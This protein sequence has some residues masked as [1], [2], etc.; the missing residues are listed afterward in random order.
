VNLINLFTSGQ[1]DTNSTV[2]KNGGKGHNLIEM[3]RS[4]INVPTGLVIPTAICNQYR[5]DT[6]AGKTLL[7]DQVT[8]AVMEALETHIYPETNHKLLSVR[9][10]APV[11][12]AGM[13]DTLL[14]VGAGY[15]DKDLH[16][17]LKADC[18]RRFVE[19]YADVVMEHKGKI[20]DPVKWMKTIKK[21]IPEVKDII[22]NSIQAVWDSFDNERCVHY[23]K[24]NKIPND[25]GTAVVIQSMVFG[26]YN[27]NSGSGVMFTRNPNT[28]AKEIFG[29]FLTNCQGED[30][31][32]GAITAPP[33]SEM[34][35]W[36]SKLYNELV[37]IGEGLEL[38]NKDLQE[39]EF[40]VEDGVLSILQTRNPLR[41]SYAEIKIALDLLEEGVIEELGDRITEGTF[42]KLRVPVLPADFKKKA[43][44]KGIGSGGYFAT[45]KAAFSVKEVMESAEPTI[46]VAEETT[47]DDIKAM[48]KA[49]GIL[50]FKGS[51]TCHAAVVA[52]GMNKPCVVGCP[53]VEDDFAFGTF[54]YVLIDGQTG[55]VYLSEM[56][57]DLEFNTNIPVELLGSLFEV[58][59]T[60]EDWIMVHNYE[61][62]LSLEDYIYKIGV[63]VEGLTSEELIDLAER[64]D[65]VVL[66]NPERRDKVSD[67]LGEP[68]PEGMENARELDSHIG[69]YNLENV[70][71]DSG[72][73]V[74]SN[75]AKA[76][77]TMADVMNPDFIGYIEKDFI[78][79]VMGDAETFEKISEQLG[80]S[81]RV[82]AMES[83]LGL[84]EKRIHIG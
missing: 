70:F 81:S 8:E 56:P 5:A 24:M 37:K 43:N 10:G 33:I 2:N 41:S 22:R 16:K 53:D 79:N 50:T 35:K 71:F 57:F 42:M 67:F 38:K 26:N 11:S 3:K 30:V 76:Y 32:A 19:M 63:P 28:G 49:E 29:D 7:L 40:T 31:V 59:I 46:L 74:T 52:R 20:E 6:D 17:E 54:S 18:R 44:A 36:N 27:D 21:H 60:E 73:W 45:G 68:N 83:A 58:A 78:D 61:E 69:D 48:E 62:A 14:N 23:R 51:A 12:M 15:H 80:L 75:V 9:S 4:G 13:M 25:M 65:K 39:I 47:P 66:I 55:E 34:K 1:I 82:V 64:F 77:K 84:L 72:T